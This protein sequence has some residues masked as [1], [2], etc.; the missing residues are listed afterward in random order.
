MFFPECVDL[1]Y[2]TFVDGQD[3][4]YANYDNEMFGQYQ[5]QA[6][7]KNGYAY[8]KHTANDRLIWFGS[9]GFWI[10]TSQ[11]VF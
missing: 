4:V 5:K 6:E 10:I 2:I 1:L 7:N 11:L 3:H 8:Y 9:C